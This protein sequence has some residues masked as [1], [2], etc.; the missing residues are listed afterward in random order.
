[1]QSFKKQFAANL[2]ATENGLP[3]LIGETS[4][5]KPITFMVASMD[6]GNK[7]Y[8]Q[9]IFSMNR[10]LAEEY[11]EPGKAPLDVQRSSQLKI[12]C[13]HVVKGWENVLDDD[14]KE[15]DCNYNNVYA[16]LSDPELYVVYD[17]VLEA[18][19]N[20]SRFTKKSMDKAVKN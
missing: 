14:G 5:G 15:M 4:D 17:K 19:T 13:K 16:I 6:N 7:P 12:V 2:D 8:T 9:A 11:G 18:A 20:Q 3:A 10:D 1:M